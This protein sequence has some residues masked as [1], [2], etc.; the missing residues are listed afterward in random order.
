MAFSPTVSNIELRGLI[1]LLIPN[2]NLPYVI[3]TN[4]ANYF[5]FI[6]SLFSFFFLF[7]FCFIKDYT[8]NLC[9]IYY[10]WDLKFLN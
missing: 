1:L 8:E 10:M 9:Q 4:C 5:F 6:F 3:P 2:E 7:L